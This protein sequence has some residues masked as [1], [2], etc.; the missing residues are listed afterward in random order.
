LDAFKMRMSQMSLEDRAKRLFVKSV[1]VLKL[2]CFQNGAIIAAPTSHSYCD[3]IWKALKMSPLTPDRSEYH[4]VWI[5]DGTSIAMALDATGNYDYAKRFYEWCMQ[6]QDHSG[7]WLQCYWP[8]GRRARDNLELDEVGTPIFGT[9]HH[10]LAT[11]D[12]DFIYNT[13]PMT[14]RAATFII[15]NLTTDGLTTASYD[16]WEERWGCHLYSNVAAVAG[17]LSASYHAELLGEDACREKWANAAQNLKK[18]I[19]EKFLP[20]R[21]GGFVRSINP[22]DRTIDIS[23]LGLV[24]PFSLLP[25]EDIYMVRT[26]KEIEERLVENGGVMRYLGDRY[27]GVPEHRPW[28]ETKGNFWISSTLWLTLYY[29]E[30]KN[31]SK[32]IK[33]Y[34]WVVDNSTDDFLLPQQIDRNGKPRSAI[35]Y[36]LAHALFVLATLK[37]RESSL[38]T[39]G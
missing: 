39:L 36:G 32:A 37:L 38:R 34:D 22:L 19:I 18:A 28:I 6:V 14:Q 31:W 11:K 9:Y 15:R 27:D 24:F 1:D 13:W 7:C 10:Y 30:A 33:H 5:R 21:K 3:H 29:L 25:P 12:R 20:S 16:L 4:L 26:V 8:D 2:L 17:L 35:P 23:V